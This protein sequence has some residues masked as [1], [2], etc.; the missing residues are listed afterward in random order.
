MSD[1]LY[2]VDNSAPKATV[3]EYLMEWCGISKQMDIA[4]GYLEVGGLLTLDANWQKLDKI[5]IILGNEVTKRTSDVL[6]GAAAPFLTQMK[7]SLNAEQEKNDFLLGVPAI[8]AALKSKKIECRVFDKGKFHAKAYITY[9]RD[10]AKAAFPKSMNVPDGYALVGSSNFTAAGLTK[11]VELNVQIRDNVNELQSWFDARWDE[12]VDITDAVLKIIEDQVREFSPYEVYLRSMYEFFR[13]HEETVS[14]WENESSVV[15]K[16]LSQYQKDGYNNLVQIADKYSGAF[17]CDGVGLGKT[18]VGMMLIERFV[19]QERRNVVLVV[20][21][22]ARKSVWET[23]IA[24]FMPELLDGFYPFRIVNHTDF[25]RENMKNF[26]VQIAAQGEVVIID[27]AHHFRN[28]DGKAYR[29]FFDILAE[30]PKKKVFMLTATPI[31]NSFLDLQ[32]LIELF[33]HRQD[34]Y[35]KSIGVNSVQGH[36]R[37]LEKMVDEQCAEGA[38]ESAQVQSA[39]ADDPLVKE[40]VVQRSRAYVKQSLNA[41]EGAKVLFPKE[42]KP[43][44]ANYS[45]RRTCGDLLEHFTALFNRR[46]S[47]GEPIQIL[48][49]A[50]YSPYEK[51]Y[52]IGDPDKIDPMKSGRQNQIV[53]LL[54]QLLL[55]R[56]ESSVAAFQDTC[57]RIYQRLKTFM[58]DYRDEK[59]HLVDKTLAQQSDVIEFVDEYIKANLVADDEDVEDFIADLPDYVWNVE[60]DLSIDDFDIGTMLEDTVLDLNNLSQLIRDMMSFDPSKDDKLNALKKL[61]SDEPRLQGRKILVFTEYRATAKYLE[62]ELKKAGVSG[63][64]EIDGQSNVD[65]HEM[66]RNFSPYYNDTTS[67][68]VGANEIRVLIATDVLSEGLNLQD[69]SRLIN[70][71]LHWNPVRLMQRIGRVDRRRN[72]VVETK[73]L[74]DHPELAPDRDDVFYWNFLPPDELES[75]L[76]LYHTVSRKTLRISKVFGIEGKKLLTPQDDFDALA[77]FNAQYEGST[78]PMEEVSLAYQQLMSD[79]PGYAESVK[80]LPAKMFSGKVS[81]TSKGVFFCYELPVKNLDGTMAEKGIFRWFLY[82][83]VDKSVVEEVLP[84]WKSIHCDKNQPRVLTLGD[85]AF[86]FIRKDMEKHIRNTYLKSIQAPLGASARLVTWMELV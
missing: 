63:V 60:E 64:F 49:L 7:D 58:V 26:M 61:L 27:E 78:S 81:S 20:P 30:G 40:L 28:R 10:E 32:H 43:V 51:A 42:K 15:F 34:D 44:V 21:A 4:T 11:N 1:N 73:L 3:K 55:K 2:I 12:S 52:Y 74:A 16:T 83:P 76:A 85:E 72:A 86:A 41:E 31:N 77:D 62:R 66:V 24:K 45:M 68:E 65:R 23:T 22:A 33:T 67:A 50:V 70:Y 69:A 25:I 18:F 9:F 57:V 82:N 17:L 47:R 29:K 6:K 84:I 19:K 36:F 8:V 5:R 13:E 39:F 80:N 14:E 53:A 54:R 56:F 75:L 38:Q 71:E 46:N 59:P 48:S 37:L 79:N 35:F